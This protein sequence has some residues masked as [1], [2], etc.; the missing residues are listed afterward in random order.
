MTIKS[1][2]RLYGYKKYKKKRRKHCIVILLCYRKLLR[3]L[4][5]NNSLRNFERKCEIAT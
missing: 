1:N 2:N 4:I 5:K 3:F